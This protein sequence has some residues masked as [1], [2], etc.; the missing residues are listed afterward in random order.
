MEKDLALIENRFNELKESGTPSLIPDGIVNVEK[1]K[2]AKIKIMW[3]LKEPH[4]EGNGGWDMRDFLKQPENLTKR[5]DNWPWKGTYKMLMQ[6]TWGILHDFQSHEKT[7]N[8]WHRLGDEK[9]L[10]ILNEIA[11]INLKK[12]PGH[13]NSSYDPE[14]R[15]AYKTNKEL[16][17][18]QINAIKPDFVICGGTYKFIKRDIK[19]LSKNQSV[20]INNNHPNLEVTKQILIITMRY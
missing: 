2:K 9:V 1:Y 14:I 7:L 3:I 17:W 13:R 18:L 5:K 16:I 10:S 19:L 11:Y 20:F 8:D 4:D 6:L 15:A 12:T